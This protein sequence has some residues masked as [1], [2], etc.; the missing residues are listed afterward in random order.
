LYFFIANKS[1]PGRNAFVVAVA[2]VCIC[3]V[4]TSLERL[5]GNVLVCEI[6]G[7]PDVENG[8]SDSREDPSFK[9]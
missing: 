1:T 4:V 8:Q 6:D 2:T 3:V 9:K 5:A 7:R